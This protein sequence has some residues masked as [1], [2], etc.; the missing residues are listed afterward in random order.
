[1]RTSSEPYP[2][3]LFSR[4]ASYPHSVPPAPAPRRRFSPGGPAGTTSAYFKALREAELA[5]WNKR[6]GNVETEVG[7]Y[8][9]AQAELTAQR[10]AER[11]LFAAI[12][13]ISLAGLGLACGQLVRLAHGW[14]DFT[15][16][17]QYLIG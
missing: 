10:R 8:R 3:P 12:G 11:W 16:L 14:T 6:G 4:T 17:V 9:R 2:Q 7:P 1:M 5:A 13:I 15:R